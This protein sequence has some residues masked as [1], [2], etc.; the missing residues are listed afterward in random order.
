MGVDRAAST[1]MKGD[2][3]SLQDR[4]VKQTERIIFFD[5]VTEV[6]ESVA[7]SLQ[8]L[9][10]SVEE[11]DFLKSKGLG[12]LSNYCIPRRTYPTMWIQFGSKHYKF[13]THSSSS[14]AECCWRCRS[15]TASETFSNTLAQPATPRWI[16]SEISSTARQ[17]TPSG[18]S[19]TPIQSAFPP[20]VN[21]VRQRPSIYICL[22][23]K[24]HTITWLRKS[25][26]WSNSRRKRRT[27]KRTWRR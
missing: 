6:Y 21:K 1:R 20:A 16:G 10:L 13:S 11:K 2:I 26:I 19:L 5:D 24:A 15:Q 22:R 18:N 3:L 23:R 7:R 25:L 12:Y 8:D 17:K 14:Y 27:R 4:L 9:V